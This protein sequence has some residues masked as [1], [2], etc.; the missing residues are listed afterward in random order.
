MGN[1]ANNDT[2]AP[3]GSRRGAFCSVRGA[4]SVSGVHFQWVGCIV[5]SPLENEQYYDI[6]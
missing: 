2:N 1:H 6:L 4:F 5:F 3:R